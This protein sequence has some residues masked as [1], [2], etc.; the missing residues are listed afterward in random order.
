MGCSIGSDMVLGSVFSMVL[1]SVF[2]ARH[3]VNGQL[4]QRI[5]PSPFK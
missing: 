1:G 3:A 5:A 2:S 4:P